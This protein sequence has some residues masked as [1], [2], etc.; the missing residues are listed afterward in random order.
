MKLF[1]YAVKK[2]II[3][4]IVI[5]SIALLGVFSLN[6]LPLL[7]LPDTS[8]PSLRVQVS[9]RS[10][11]PQ[12]IENLITSPLEGAMGGVSHLKKM[13]SASAGNNSFIRLEFEL[14]TDMDLASMEVRDR[15]DQVR[16]ELPDDVGRIRVRRFQTTDIPIMNY[17]L[18]WEGSQSELNNIAQNLIVPRLLRIDGIADVDVQGL[19]S[20]EI[21]V[22]LNSDLMESYGVDID[23][24]NR[25]LSRN[26]I[27]TSGGYILDGGRKYVVRSI[28]EF[29]NIDEIPLLPV[30]GNT[31][32]LGDIGK[33]T[34]DYPERNFYQRLN[35]IDSVS[36]RVFKSS[37]AN[38][39]DV[40]EEVKTVFAELKSDPKME[41]LSFYLFFDQS[42]EITNSLEN[43]RNA[44]I[45][46]GVL[47]V[48]MLFLFLWKVRSTIIIALSIP[49]S[50]LCTFAFMFLLRR[51]TGSNIS[52]NIISLSGLMLA[53]GMLVDNGV[54]VLENIFRHKEEG[55]GPI[56]AAIKG[57]SEV[58]TAVLAATLTTIIVFVPLVFMSKTSFGRFMG[59]F[60]VAIV[61][62]LV[63]SL[64]VAFTLIP[65]IA[66]RLFTGEEKKRHLV[67]DWLRGK[68]GSLMR[69]TLGSWWSRLIVTSSILLIL[70]GSWQLFKQIEREFTPP[71]PSR[72]MDI[73]VETPRSAD[74]DEVNEVFN[75]VENTLLEH[76]ED[77]EIRMISTNFRAGRRSRITV[78]FE[79]VEESKFNTSD[80][81]NKVRGVLPEIPG[82]AFKVGRSF[83]IG[84]GQL[85]ISVELKGPDSGVIA[86]LAEDVKNRIGSIPGVKDVDTSLESGDEEIRVAVDRTKAR[87]YGLSSN[88]VAQA[89][90]S[91]LS[92]RTSNSF[93]TLDEEI[94]I[95]VQLRE[96]DR[97]N[98]EQLKQV[99]FENGGQELTSLGTL[100][101][102]RIE[103]GPIS[104]Q[105]DDG[106]E[107]VT[108]FA[109]TDRRGMFT[110]RGEIT[111]RLSDLEMPAGYSW[112]M[113][114]N[115][116]R[117]QQ[118]QQQS[119]F[120]ILLAIVLIYLVIAALFES[121]IHP[122]TILL[123]VPFS[124]T[125]VAV[126]FYFTGT[127]LNNNSWLGVIVLFGIVVNNSI[128]LVDHINRLRKNGMGRHEAII[129][130]G[131]DRLRPI[132]MTA[133]TTL[134]GL[135]PMVAPVLFPNIFGPI[136][137]RA[138]LYAPIA[139]ALVGGLTTSTFLTLIVTPTFY[140]LMDDLERF[141]KRVF[142]YVVR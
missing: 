1:E 95:K 141:S 93:K 26:N 84:G 102:F 42:N 73:T 140:T 138:G 48:V 70:F 53:V 77:F 103:K 114:S 54:V 22:E 13:S 111:N 60:G 115:F 135:S 38:I 24:V 78:F 35:N 57:A 65:L 63:A 18:A 122:I 71:S 116:R 79:D 34:Y 81:Q 117:F 5:V 45:V 110:L 96:Q 89:I 129:K 64:V 68:Y 99:N 32:K 8:F 58:G 108:V 136:E 134:L 74:L 3:T 130:G 40:S 7:F 87:Q 137:G 20:K 98:L 61:T 127:T 125:G 101:D 11:S 10:T 28:G 94:P 132:L 142:S 80:L 27:N 83:G 82:Y 100:A 85:G 33:I 43:L 9:Y 128:I 25:S 39:V 76:R 51:F 50:L 41:G 49:L 37:T 105:R 55:E 56:N 120:A 88:Q 121:F 12:E 46:G 112:Q 92:V 69:W 104:I 2:P 36:V 47:A 62:A 118:S 16:G 30:G 86:I 91:N 131:Q 124:I 75:Q 106:D 123:S 72:R 14:G 139:L 29:R 23:D 44:G 59:D 31:I 109:N 119:T 67:I 4:V 17:S 6:R 90:S 19:R 133:A 21:F 97:A 15:I 107:I 126:L 66:S 113:G 52:L